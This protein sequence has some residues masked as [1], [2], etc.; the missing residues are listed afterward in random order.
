MK[1]EKISENQ[2][3]CTLNKDDLIDREL[4][5]SELAYGTEKANTLFWDIK[6]QAFYEFG[7]EVDDIPIMIEAI[8]VSDECLI[9]VIT[10]VEDPDELDTRF[11]KFSSFNARDNSDTADDEFYADEIINS[12]GQPDDDL[13][14]V[15]EDNIKDDSGDYPELH[16]GNLT[17]KTVHIQSNLNKLY[18]FRTLQEVI[19]LAKIVQGIYQG[20]NTLYKNPVS[21]IYYLEIY[22]SDHTPEEFN[23]VC[24]IVSEFGNSERLTYASS[25]YFN[26]HFEIII[27]DQA[28]QIL[29]NM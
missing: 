2:I 21:S 17:A 9:L 16:D 15:M 20:N 8:P 23:R 18:T 4:K 27:K 12:M 26:E 29:S 13:V 28:L 1:I 6:Q 25:S 5:I 3:R 14:D 7:F 22:M 19:D 24:N 11:S 10:K